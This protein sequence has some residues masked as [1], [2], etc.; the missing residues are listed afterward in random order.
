MHY[1]ELKKMK[2]RMPRVK[3]IFDF[4]YAVRPAISPDGRTIAISGAHNIYFIDSVTLKLVQGVACG[5]ASYIKMNNSHVFAKHIRSPNTVG[6]LQNEWS[7]ISF[8]GTHHLTYYR[9]EMMVRDT[10]R[11]QYIISNDNLEDVFGIY[12]QSLDPCK[13]A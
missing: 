12:A 4:D 2:N 11:L 10:D 8:K 1:K 3:L 13:T 5:S 7:V 6:D 9:S